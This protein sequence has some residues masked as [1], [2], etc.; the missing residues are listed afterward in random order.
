MTDR[1][2]ATAGDWAL[3]SD[4]IQWML[5]RRYK[6]GKW[7][8]ISFVRSSRD[9]LERCIREWGV[10]NALAAELLAGLPTSFDQ[11]KAAQAFPEAVAAGMLA[12]VSPP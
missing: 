6:D 2:F 9:I 4:G 10:D 7:R 1:V 8:G 11:W 5:M 3:A 12:D